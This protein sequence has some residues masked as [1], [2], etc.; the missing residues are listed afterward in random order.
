MGNRVR[1]LYVT[2]AVASA[3]ALAGALSYAAHA[4]DAPTDGQVAQADTGED[5]RTLEAIIVTARRREESAQEVPISI[6]ALSQESLIQQ[7][8]RTV[9]DLERNV[10]GISICCA[11]GSPGYMFIRGVPGVIG[12]FAEVPTDLSGSGLYFDLGNAQVLKGPQGTLF[13]LSTNGGAILYEPARPTEYFE[14]HG[15]LTLGNYG[16]RTVEG[17]V[18]LPVSDR[19]LLRAGVMYQHT[20]GYIENVATGQELAEE[21]YVIAR[22]SATMRLTE[23][24]ENYLLVNYHKSDGTP[25]VYVPYAV[26][27]T[28]VLRSVY[29]ADAVDAW[30]AQQ[31]ALGRYKVVGLDVTPSS[32]VEKWNVVDIATFRISD[33]L[34][35]KNIAG[36][37]QTRSFTINDTD[38]SPFPLFGTSL[39]TGRPGPDRVYTLEPQLQGEALSGRLSF[40][41]GSFNS[42]SDPAEPVASYSVAVGN[43]SGTMSRNEATTH[44]LYAEGTV[45]ITDSLN[46]TAGY[47]YTWDERE[48]WQQRLNAAGEPAGAPTTRHGKWE[49]GTYR[50]SLT[51]QPSSDVMLY[52]TNSKG[53]SSGGFNGGTVPASMALYDP[54][55]LNNFELGIKSD[56]Y[57]GDAQLRTNFAAY[58]GKYDDI[59][60]SVTTA[61]IDPVTNSQSL[62]VLTRNAATGEIKGVEGEFTFIPVDQLE[63]SGNFSYMDAEYTDYVDLDPTDPTGQTQLDLSGTAFVY[64]PEW[65]YTVGLTWHLPIP[66]EFGQLSFSA[67]YNWQDAVANTARLRPLP[68]GSETPSF[69][70]ANANLNW[71]GVAGNDAID[72]M[73]YVTN[74]T[75]TEWAN[76]QFGAYDVLGLWGLAVAVPRQWGLRVRYTF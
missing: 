43:R 28:G 24:F 60:V 48:Q 49:K 27:P 71:R 67:T 76:G 50:L 9:T 56:W 36:F 75:G 70:S 8:I 15:A 34:T 3:L 25:A 33:D 19:L 29:G 6:T 5:A 65:K 44:S 35:F 16:R 23:R 11:R 7:D 14:G 21:N 64:T 51:W 55:S 42:W 46:F 62:V 31:Q 10:P 66:Q 37:V 40:V 12:Y 2:R 26:N 4:Q 30:F 38:G 17:V 47:R 20:D 41:A 53:Y 59:Q 32:D 18:N 61:V 45:S 13:G 52:F 58:Y 39:P 74:L 72:A 1:P 73:L 68:F 54:E 22:V 57:F 69:G 63:L